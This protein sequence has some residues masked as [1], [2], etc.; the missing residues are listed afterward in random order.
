LVAGA[1]EFSQPGYLHVAL[2]LAACSV[3]L[4]FLHAIPLPWQAYRFH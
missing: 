2:V 3:M 4:L 1:G